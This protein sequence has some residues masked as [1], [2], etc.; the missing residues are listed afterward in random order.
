VQGAPDFDKGR[1][2]NSMPVETQ[3]VDSA[4]QFLFSKVLEQAQRDGVSLS[5]VE[6][7][8]LV[9][10]EGSASSGDV[11]A[12]QEFEVE[13][14]DQQSEAKIAKLFQRAYGYDKK[15][16][17]EENPWK[18]AL[19]ALRKADIYMLVM[20]DQAGIPRPRSYVAVPSAFDPED[21]LFAVFEI[22]V[23]A[24]GFVIVFDPLRWGWVRSDLIRLA[25]MLISIGI[26]W[27]VGKVWGRR[28][29]SRKFGSQRKSP[30]IDQA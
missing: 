1:V 20:V 18:Q 7:R 11:K 17:D 5:D 28:M 25:V 10:S 6:K 14:D 30:E 27:F 19:D 2:E 9:F 4:K 8:M 24:A 15:M 12:E 21:I 16:S 26:C 3:T 22:G 29:V 13:F 23:L